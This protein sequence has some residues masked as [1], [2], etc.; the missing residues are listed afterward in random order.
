MG[1]IVLMAGRSR[2]GVRAAPFSALTSAEHS[3]WSALPVTGALRM[4]HRAAAS[5]YADAQHTNTDMPERRGM[6]YC[7]AAARAPSIGTLGCER[8]SPQII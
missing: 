1:A 5:C 3:G 4:Q 8:Y 6:F 7:I 2:H